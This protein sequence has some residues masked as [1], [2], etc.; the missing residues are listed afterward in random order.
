MPT[1]N[2]F[3]IVLKNTSDVHKAINDIAFDRIYIEQAYIKG[4]DGWQWRIRKTESSNSSINY[5]STIKLK[6]ETRLIELEQEIDERDYDDLI[7]EATSILYKYRYIVFDEQNK[8]W[9]I[10]F[11]QDPMIKS[12]YFTM[13]ELEA[14]EGV[15]GIEYVPSFIQDHVLFYVPQ[16]QNSKY[17]SKNIV[18]VEYAENLYNE[19]L[20]E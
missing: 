16:E 14:P 18:D 7:N 3:K 12:F 8:T 17:S 4:D 11:F 13:A 20:K 5:L 9:E 10:D 19:L 6:K 2:E 15:V 1:E